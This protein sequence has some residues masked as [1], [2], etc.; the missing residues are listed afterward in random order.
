FAVLFIPEDLSYIVYYVEYADL[1]APATAS[2]IHAGPAG[3]NGPIVL[4][5]SGVPTEMSGSF[6]RVLTADDFR[7]GGG[8][9]E[10]GDVITAILYGGAYANVHSR[11]SPGG[12]IRGQ[13]YL[14]E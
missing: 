8:L 1:N 5:F 3:M 10:W 13:T 2:H 9:P 14:I 11:T 4:K 6:S 12:E 7:P